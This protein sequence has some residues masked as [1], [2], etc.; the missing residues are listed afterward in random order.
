M[1][2]LASQNGTVGMR[3]AWTILSQGGS[4]LDAVET[5]TRHIEDDPDDHT[6]GYGGYP[7]LIGEV[8]LDASIMD[9][10]TRAAGAVGALKHYRAAVSVARK[11]MEH[12]PHAVLVGEGA[13]RFAAEVGF[14]QENL[15]TA[16]ARDVYIAGLAGRFPPRYKDFGPVI[17]IL[18]GLIARMADEG[19]TIHSPGTVNFIAQD[20]GGNIASAAS[21]SGWGWKY[22]GRV[23]DSTVIG[24]GNYADSRYGAATCAGWG[25][26]AIRAGAARGV[27]A[28]LEAGHSLDDACRRAFDDV[29][30]LD[31]TWSNAPLTMLGLDRAGNH[32]S[33]TTIPGRKYLAWTEKM[34]T[35]DELTCT[36][37]ANATA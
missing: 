28:R 19:Q 4:A 10:T 6:V 11:V 14:Q 18:K 8:E 27:I 5:A 33:C 36:F 21:T 30:D 31:S 32:T 7:N 29:A 1:I 13:T 20:A 12:L 26:L 16:D 23:G 3:P 35:F 9:G 15:L 34:P 17:P 24:A 37:I 2:L 25:E 22:P